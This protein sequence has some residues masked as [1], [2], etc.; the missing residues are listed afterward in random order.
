MVEPSASKRLQALFNVDRLLSKGPSIQGMIA[1]IKKELG[2]IFGK[3]RVHFTFGGPNSAARTDSQSMNKASGD[4]FVRSLGAFVIT[5]RSPLAIKGNLEKFCREKN[6]KPARRSIKSIL[7][8]PVRY[9]NRV[10][11]ALILENGRSPNA[12]S[13]EDEIFLIAVA[14]RVGAE[15]VNSELIAEKNRLDAEISQLALFDPLTDLPNQRYFNLIVEMELKKAKGYSRQLSLAMIDVDRF[16]NMNARLGKK[17]A[18]KLLVH[19]AQTLKRNVRDTDFVARYSAGE[20]VILLPEALNEAAVNVAD[21]VR[22]AVERT[23]F[24]AKGLGKKKVTISVGVATY[25]SSAEN[26]PALLEQVGKALKKAK[27]LGRNQV[28]AL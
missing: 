23:P 17:R 2:A 19:V 15:I 10:Y 26:L 14:G 12:F 11:G 22:T 4:A 7:G 25:P 13:G 6:I 27:Q 20:F 1:G 21:R 8:V 18:D 28:V 16:R 24:A 9:R 5:K 3:T